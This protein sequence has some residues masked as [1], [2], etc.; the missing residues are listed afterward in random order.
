MTSKTKKL[1][2]NLNLL[3]ISLSN[4]TRTQKTYGNST[5]QH[6]LSRRKE[7]KLASKM[8]Y[9]T[10]QKTSKSYRL[11]QCLIF[12]LLMYICA[13]RKLRHQKQTYIDW[14][15]WICF[16]SMYICF[17]CFFHKKVNGQSRISRNNINI[18]KYKHMMGK[19][20]RESRDFS[21]SEKSFLERISKIKKL[22]S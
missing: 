1:Y 20:L 7:E 11:N 9:T 15:Q 12:L 18:F 3:I 13:C 2:T 6:N 21:F 14:K 10:F 22:N 19:E 17:W 5:Q 8:K 16:Q 4:Y